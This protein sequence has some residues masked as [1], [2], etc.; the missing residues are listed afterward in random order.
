MERLLL[1]VCAAAM[2]CGFS[3]Y[4][5]ENWQEYA[6]GKEIAEATPTMVWLVSIS[7]IG[8]SFVFIGLNFL[9]LT[10][11]I[12]E[13]GE[14]FLYLSAA[15]SLAAASIIGVVV[16]AHK[17]VEYLLDRGLIKGFRYSLLLPLWVLFVIGFFGVELPRVN[18]VWSQEYR[19]AQRA[20]YRLIPAER[21]TP[22]DMRP[23]SDSEI[24]PETVPEILPKLEIRDS[25]N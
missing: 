21:V 3:R 5:N 15:L 17:Y 16:L 23:A 22:A 19:L 1:L 7:L 14:L 10:D 25:V 20:A 24:L 11:L 6:R 8:L 13:G 9:S 12:D 18:W 2:L 4:S